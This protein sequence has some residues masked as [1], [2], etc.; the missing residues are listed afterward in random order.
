[1]WKLRYRGSLGD[2]TNVYFPLNTIF[3]NDLFNECGI[4]DKY[5]KIILKI[6]IPLLWKK[7]EAEEFVT[8]YPFDVTGQETKKV[9][10]KKIVHFVD[11]VEPDNFIKIKRSISIKTALDKIDYEEV[12]TF[13]KELKEQ[14]FLKNYLEALIKLF[15]LNQD[16]IFDIENIEQ[17]NKS[18][19][20]FVINKR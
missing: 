11:K 7:H 10:N 13:Y 14:G 12:I 1:M 2:K 19:K 17:I 5:Q 18:H 9:D 15:G 16:L 4:P 6:N 20:P 3:L 8:G